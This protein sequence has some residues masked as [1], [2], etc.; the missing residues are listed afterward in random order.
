MPFIHVQT[1][2]AIT[3]EQAKNIKTHLG[4]AITAVPGKTENW[5]MVETEGDKQL[6]FQGTDA[7]G[8][9]GRGSAVR[10]SI[11]QCAEYADQQHYRNS[12]GYTKN[13]NRQNLC[14]LYVYRELGLEQLEF[15][16]GNKNA[17]PVRDVL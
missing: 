2:T 13:S 12:A 11:V 17:V 6:F 3:D 7:A 15:L 4:L 8:S 5:L 1:N 10:K 16:M 9:N 14:K